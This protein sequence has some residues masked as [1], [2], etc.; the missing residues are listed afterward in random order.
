[1][2]AQPPPPAVTAE[3][4]AGTTVSSAATETMDGAATLPADRAVLYNHILCPAEE[5]IDPEGGA[6]IGRSAVCRIPIVS[7]Q[8]GEG[9]T[10]LILVGGM[11]GGYEWNTILLAYRILDHL[12]QNPELIPPSLTIHLIPNANPDGLYAVT[13]RTG[14]FSAADVAEN[15]EM[16][17]FNGHYV[18]LNRN[19]DCDWTPNAMWRDSPISGGSAPFSEPENQ[20]LRDF[21]LGKDP[22]A[23]LFLHSAATGVYISGCGQPDPASTTLGKVYSNASGYP[24]YDGFHYYD[25]TGDA[26]DWLATQGI[27]S[28]TVELSTHEALDWNMNL[29]GLSALIDHITAATEEIAQTFQQRSD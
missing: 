5:D 12:R 13:R 28:I 2:E 21:I 24:L 11:H 25:V 26:G 29:L 14:R 19:W 23:A 10:P 15:T 22:A 17:R 27:P 20:A 16:G 7:Y 8:L 6:I 1:L 4:M 9:A 3:G 18:D